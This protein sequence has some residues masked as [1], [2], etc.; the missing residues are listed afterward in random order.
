MAAVHL[1]PNICLSFDGLGVAAVREE[2]AIC[3]VGK[4][5]AGHEWSCRAGRDGERMQTLQCT[6]S[7]FPLHFWVA[8]CQLL[9][10]TGS[11]QLVIDSCRSW[12]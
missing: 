9:Y 2:G 11:A 10:T 6:G 5:A 7:H 1:A 12:M 8:L 3:C 4:T